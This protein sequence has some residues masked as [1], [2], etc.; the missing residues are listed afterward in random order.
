MYQSI[1]IIDL[2][3]VCRFVLLYVKFILFGSSVE[4]L[5]DV[6]CAVYIISLHF[7]DLLTCLYV[8]A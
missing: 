6:Q 5:V 8:V 4:N 1:Q 3:C 7:P 2:N